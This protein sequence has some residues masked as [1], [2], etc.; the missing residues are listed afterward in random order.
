MNQ[1]ES[2]QRRCR[3]DAETSTQDARTTFHGGDRWSAGATRDDDDG[4]RRGTWRVISVDL[5]TST[6]H[7]VEWRFASDRCTME[8]IRSIIQTIVV[9]SM[10]MHVLHMDINR[11]PQGLKHQRNKE[12]R[13]KKDEQSNKAAGS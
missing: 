11:V 4:R 9:R 6:L 12:G 13:K 3:D 7:G 1:S 5:E 8:S 10:P 2:S